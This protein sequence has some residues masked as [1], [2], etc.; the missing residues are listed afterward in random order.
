MV[1]ETRMQQASHHSSDL[2]LDEMI[3]DLNRLSWKKHV[4]QSYPGR[5]DI[6]VPEGSMFPGMASAL[7]PT[8]IWDKVAR[9]GLKVHLVPGDH[10]SIFSGGQDSS[11]AEK[12][13]DCLDRARSIETI[14][15]SFRLSLRAS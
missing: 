4:R 14:R 9:G 15:T 5:I 7:D 8:V 11:V 3:R 6:I 10:N 12:L 1:K 13:R 2:E